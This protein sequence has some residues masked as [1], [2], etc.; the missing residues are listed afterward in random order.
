MSPAAG[1]RGRGARIWA[2]TCFCASEAPRKGLVS[3]RGC[4]RKLTERWSPVPPAGGVSSLPPRGRWLARRASRRGDEKAIG[5]PPR[6]RKPR[7]SFL[8]SLPLRG[9]CVLRCRWQMKGDTNLGRHLLLRKQSDAQRLSVNPGL[10]RLA[11]IERGLS[12]PVPPAG[13]S[14]VLRRPAGDHLSASR[15]SA[16]PLK[17][18]LWLGENFHPGRPLSAGSSSR[19]H[20]TFP[21]KQA[22]LHFANPIRIPQ[23]HATFV[24]NAGA[25][26]KIPE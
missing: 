14:A 6:Y 13:G 25:I 23:P 4:Q 10:A 19:G 20:Y 1:G 26:S 16:P 22:T 3:T 12:S 7:P 8:V 18:R 9:I 21:P 24:P 11:V 17:G 5:L 15:C 2:D